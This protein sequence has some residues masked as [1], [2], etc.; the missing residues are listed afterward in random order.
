MEPEQ[1]LDAADLELAERAQHAT[2]RRLAVGVVHDQL[3]DHR[4]VERLISEPTPTPESTRTPG[5][6]GSR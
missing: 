5:P 4:V 6:D 3:R 1:R 2:P